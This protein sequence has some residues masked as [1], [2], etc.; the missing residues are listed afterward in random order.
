MGL[1]SLKSFGAINEI[2]DCKII[3]IY[4]GDLE[5]HTFYN[6]ESLNEYYNIILFLPWNK[7]PEFVSQLKLNK[8]HPEQQSASALCRFNS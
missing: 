6:Q 4:L 7:Y 3:F 8:S 1:R 2:I 5:K